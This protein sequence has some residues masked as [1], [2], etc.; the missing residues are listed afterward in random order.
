M[1]V[2]ENKQLIRR[3]VEAVNQGDVGTLGNLFVQDDP[4]ANVAGFQRRAKEVLP[5]VR[6]TIE[7]TIA[8]RDKV[9]IRWRAEGTHRGAFDHHILGNVRA[10]GKRL[11]VTGITILQLKNGKVVEVWG[12]TS[13]LDA[14]HQLGMLP[15]HR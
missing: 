14:L 10:T 15:Q 6:L 2:A 8:E 9:V 3:L 5:D 12:E 4:D 11:S 1:P 13:E 7:D